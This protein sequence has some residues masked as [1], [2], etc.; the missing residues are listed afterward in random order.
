MTSFEQTLLR[1]VAALPE[2]NRVGVLA[3]IRYL[4]ADEVEHIPAVQ[5]IHEM[6]QSYDITEKTVEN[7]LRAVREAKYGRKAMTNLEKTILR[8]LS[9]LPENHLNNVLAFIQYLKTSRMDDKEI[10]KGF[11]QALKSIRARAKELNITQADIDAEIRAVRE[12]HAR[13]G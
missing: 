11:D 4:N 2:E 3:F 8:E 13:R 5:N 10:E 6:A 1:E 9:T 7:E 12:E